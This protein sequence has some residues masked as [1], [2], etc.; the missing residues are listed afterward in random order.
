MKKV[1]FF[2][3]PSNL[4]IYT[5]A[6]F[7]SGVVVK[8]TG[9]GITGDNSFA[10][11]PDHTTYVGRQTDDTDIVNKKYIDDRIAELEARIVALGG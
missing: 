4:D 3:Y 1:Y 5:T 9:E 11:F 7:T 8:K 10:A 6:R 2:T